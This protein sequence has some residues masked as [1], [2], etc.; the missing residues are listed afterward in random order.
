MRGYCATRRNGGVAVSV[1]AAPFIANLGG[2]EP[3]GKQE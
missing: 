3:R 1:N 2:Y